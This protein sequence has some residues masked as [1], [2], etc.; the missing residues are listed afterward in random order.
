MS[1][2][3]KVLASVG[4]GAANVDTKLEKSTYTAGEIMRGEIEVRG[5]N[6][7]QQI[8]TI[9]LTVYTTFIREAND[10]KYTDKAA[11][12]KV[13]VS[14]PFSIEAGENK[15]LSFSLSL[16]LDTPITAGKTKVWVQ[17]ELDIK[18]AVDPEDK[19][20][21]EVKPSKLAASVLDAVKGLGFRLRQ[22]ECE[23]ASGRFRGHYPF[24]QE[25]EF[26]PTGNYRSHLDEL[27]V[28][29]LSQSEQ[30]VELLMQI[31][32]KV[33]GLGSLF[34]EALDMDESFVR[35]TITTQDLPNLQAKLQQII[36][37]HL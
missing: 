21:I 24:M 25:F 33:K 14:E 35:T 30:S 23:Q 17:T 36:S 32:R 1:L 22:A 3:N 20:F 18:N 7:A 5:G 13:K 11:V 37:K 15:V 19:D 2:F 12:N 29:F 34:A 31:D 6:V 9:Y 16:P 26:A 28:V 27:E 10:K 4:I 8:D